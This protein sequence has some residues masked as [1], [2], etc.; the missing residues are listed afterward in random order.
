MP[1]RVAVLAAVLA[2]LVGLVVGLLT[3]RSIASQQQSPGP[4]AG[5]Q[6]GKGWGWIWGREDERGALNALTDALRLHALRLVR[7]GKVYDLGV[8]YDR[9]SYK[10]PGHNPG[11]IISFRTPSG[12]KRQQDLPDLVGP[13]VNPWGT[14]W[15]S[16][17]LF[18]SDNVGTQID[19]LAH[20]TEGPG[21]PHGNLANH[22][23]NAFTEER[24]GGDFG[25]RKCDASKIPPIIARGV[26]LDVA[27]YKKLDV[28]P[29]HY[30][31]GVEDLQETLRE[32]NTELKPGDVVLIR[33]GLLRFWGEA[34]HD[35]DGRLARHDTAGIT[36]E[37][38]RWLVEDRG[39]LLIGADTSGLEYHPSE[40]DRPDFIRRYKSFMPVHNYLLI[41][42]GVHI[43]E[44]HYLEDLA[45]DKVYEFC[46]IAITNKIRGATA[47]FALRPIALK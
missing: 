27:G 17:A 35:R 30:A 16:N 41:H 6:K 28:L 32:Q 43:G 37:A 26:L 1:R 11:E 18:I 8:L 47:G 3:A 13:E 5:W 19:G 9:G 24:W 40:S 23:Y 4:I 2:G 29:P 36:L 45:K 34:G 38:A 10:W 21:C 20:A 46:Y 31:I 15:H 12:V 7:E 25:P 44:F 33:T 39:A 22:W 42:Q 14:A